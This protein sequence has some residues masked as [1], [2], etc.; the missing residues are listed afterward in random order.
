VGKLELQVEPPLVEYCKVPPGPLTVPIA[1]TPPLTA[2]LL[3]VLF[4]MDSVPVG[5][6]GTTQVPGT[7]VPTRVIVL[8]Q[9]S[10]VRILA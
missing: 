10:V 2:Q 3:H 6:A 9:P 1:M 7:V 8:R 4:V 5:A